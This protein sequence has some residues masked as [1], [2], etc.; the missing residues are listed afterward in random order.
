MADS[1]LLLLNQMYGITSMTSNS[2]PDSQN[3]DAIQLQ[4]DKIGFNQETGT[5]NN[6]VAL[7]DYQNVAND[8][9]SYQTNVT[10]K[11]QGYLSDDYDTNVLQKKSGNYWIVDEDKSVVFYTGKQFV[12]MGSGSGVSGGAA[13]A[14]KDY[15]L[16]T[17][18]NQIVY[19]DGV[20]YQIVRKEIK[21]QVIVR[22]HYAGDI[23]KIGNVKE[24]SLQFSFNDENDYK[25]LRLFDETQ[26]YKIEFYQQT[27][28]NL[29]ILDE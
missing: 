14:I 6:N 19:P 7:D 28:N 9:I 27:H 2:Y 11:F 29:L 16:F 25:Q 4:Q 15:T 23:Y 3:Q 13:V 10:M 21:D 20:T 24:N 5:N 12:R 1:T 22:L 26:A 18:N 8:N 17:L